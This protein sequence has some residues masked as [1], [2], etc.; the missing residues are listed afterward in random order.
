MTKTTDVHTWADGFGRWY[1]R[2][3]VDFSG[4][5]S[6]RKG[7]ERA[8]KAIRRELVDRDEIRGP[9]YRVRLETYETDKVNGTETFREVAN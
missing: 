6:R 9:W 8:R 2:V 5:E 1:A 4:Q 7:A 3:P